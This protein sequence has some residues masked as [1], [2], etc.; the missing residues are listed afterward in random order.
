MF[1]ASSWPPDDG[2]L[3]TLLELRGKLKPLGLALQQVLQGEHRQDMAWPIGGCCWLP[4]TCPA[5]AT[6]R[7]VLCCAALWE[8]QRW[9]LQHALA[10]I[11][12]GLSLLAAAATLASNAWAVPVINRQLLPQLQQS[13]SALLQREVALGPVRWVAPMG[14]LGITPLGCMGP[15]HVGPGRVEGSSAEVQRL[16]VGLDPVQSVLQGRVVLTVKAQDAQ[17]G[18]KAGWQD[19]AVGW[20]GFIQYMPCCRWTSCRRATTAGLVI[21]T[22]PRPPPATLCQVQVVAVVG[23]PAR[24]AQRHP[25]ADL[26]APACKTAAAAVAACKG[27]QQRGACAAQQSC[28]H[29]LRPAVPASA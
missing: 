1:G 9:W 3:T 15:V 25:A 10:R 5:A 28:L 23:G 2:P 13:V 17:V 16:M 26:E 14:L 18:G 6:G 22:I 24:A 7:F 20:H 29:Q 4:V 27:Q 8:A 21:L 19:T 12:L 11:A